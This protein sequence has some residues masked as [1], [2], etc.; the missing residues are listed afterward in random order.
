MTI[1]KELEAQILRYYHVEK[2]RV[3]TIAR[4]LNIHHSVV[5]RVL[6]EAGIPKANFS[7]RESIITP[8]LSFITETFKKFPKLT[9]SRLYE[10]VRQRG[11]PGG[12]D[13]FRHSMA[14]HRPRPC[15]EAYLR[16]RTLPGEQAQVDWSHFGYVEIGKARRPLMAFVM[17]LSYS[18]KIFLRFYLNQQISNFLRGHEAAFNEWKGL[19]RVCLYDNLRSAVLERQGDAI[20]FN[21]TLLEFAAH[22]RYEPRPVAVARGNEKGRVERAIR[23]CRENFFAARAWKDIDDLNNQAIEWCNG[24]AALRPCPEDKTLTVKEAFLEEQPKLLQL[25]D[26]PYPTHERQEVRIGKTPYARFDLNDYSVPY[27]QV[28]RTV[29]VCATLSTVSILDGVANLIAEHPRSYEKGKQIEDESHI[30]DLATRKKQA[31]QHRGQNRLTAAAPASQ[32]LLIQAA[33]RGYPIA[34]IV[35][36]LLKFLD[37]YGASELNTAIKAALSKDVPHPNAVRTML[38]KQREERDLPP[39]IGIALPD[40]KRVR[41]LVIRPHQLESYDQLNMDGETETGDSSC[42]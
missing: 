19:P 30:A 32:E 35:V 2:W 7:K 41:E 11:Y 24:I 21:P 34:S 40:D 6:A 20:R 29:I 31:R 37:D 12:L 13:H 39:P 14:L 3:G 28:R 17:V 27:T 42:K 26:N 33:Q 38:E 8:F 22:Y 10:M 9:A 25:P 15:A 23:Y 18:R 36:Q 5:R 4:Q 1:S 16:L